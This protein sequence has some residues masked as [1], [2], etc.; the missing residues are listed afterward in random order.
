MRRLIAICHRVMPVLVE[1]RIVQS[2]KL[3]AVRRQV[4][5]GAVGSAWGP[6]LDQVWE[7]IRGQPGLRI[8]GHNIFLYHHPIRPGAPVLCDFG[9]E[10]TR[11][12]EK[13]GE[14]Y[15]TETPSGEAARCC[16][17]RPVQS[18]ARDAQRDLE[19]DGSKWKGVCWPIMGNLRRSDA[20]SG[21]Y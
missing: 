12:F 13:T 15:V 3:A 6:A 19:V 18:H 5:P 17:P 11:T 21:R 1:V 10:I 7:F 20:G 16:A 9:V 2:R 4:E 8:N 14:V